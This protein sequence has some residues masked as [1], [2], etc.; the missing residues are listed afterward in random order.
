MK[1]RVA[2]ERR[3]CSQEPESQ[4]NGSNTMLNVYIISNEMCYIIFYMLEWMWKRKHRI[5]KAN[6]SNIYL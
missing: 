4:R 5:G 2:E 3:R 1:A 6:M